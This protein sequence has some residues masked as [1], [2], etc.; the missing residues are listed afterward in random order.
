MRRKGN[1][2]LTGTGIVFGLIAALGWNAAAVAAD[3]S[4]T[5]K[6]KGQYSFR[7]TPVKSFSADAPGDPGGLASAPRQD[8]LRVGFFQADGNGN[9]AGRTIATTDTNT[10]ATW[11]I[12]FNWTGKYTVNPDGTGFFS[13]NAISNLV[14]TDMTVTHSG[15]T[16]HPA[17][18]GGAPFL[19]NA[20][21]CP[22]DVEGHE[23]YAFVFSAH[24]GKRIEFIQTD[25][26]GGGSK[27][28]LTGLATAREA[29][30]MGHDD[31]DQ[32]GES[33]GRGRG[34]DEGDAED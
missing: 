19:G 34:N 15:P 4:P 10:G 30:G 28:F 31:D 14:C 23:D 9:L 22:A 25:N 17:S 11:V 32:E 8:I 7:M 13:I 29:F 27:I 5:E 12:T 26:T 33:R 21:T 18:A 3:D 2:W 6:I 1:S 20:G 24:S 16:P